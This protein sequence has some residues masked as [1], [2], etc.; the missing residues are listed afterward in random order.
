MSGNNKL[1]EDTAAAIIQL[2]NALSSNPSDIS[3]LTIY[4]N[5]PEHVKDA[6]KEKI[7]KTIVDE[8]FKCNLC[9]TEIKDY[10]S[11]YQLP[12]HHLYCD[13]C[14]NIDDSGWISC[15][16]KENNMPCNHKFHISECSKTVARVAITIP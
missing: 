8:G 14:Y 1:S 9:S 5:L 7:P 16:A 12:C 3:K 4:G 13:A 10:D 11:C 15:L 6:Y 2:R